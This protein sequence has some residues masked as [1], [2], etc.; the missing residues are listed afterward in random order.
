MIFGIDAV[1]GGDLFLINKS[2]FPMQKVVL[3]GNNKSNEELLMAIDLG[4]GYIVV[5]SLNELIRLEKLVK[6]TD[7]KVKTL[8]RVNPGIEASY[9]CLY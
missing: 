3:H 5:D 8:V 4:V 9:S 1:S 6:N 7:N 2:H